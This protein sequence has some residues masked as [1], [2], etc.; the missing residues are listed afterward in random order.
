MP[1][2]FLVIELLGDKKKGGWDALRIFFALGLQFG[3]FR[4][5][6][7][8]LSFITYCPTCSFLLFLSCMG[9][10]LL[11]HTLT[12]ILVVFLKK[13]REREINACTNPLFIQKSPTELLLKEK[14]SRI[15]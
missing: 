9:F 7:N 4:D 11:K 1:L 10:N 15:Q 8:K 3:F 14:T 6:L 12:A 5:V 13:E 2:N